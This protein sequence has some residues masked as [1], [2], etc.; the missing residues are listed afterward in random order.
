MLFLEHFF[1]YCTLFK[2]N[3]FIFQLLA[4]PYLM[5]FK[6]FLDKK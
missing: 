2:T 3:G 5:G 4:S 6:K 1:T